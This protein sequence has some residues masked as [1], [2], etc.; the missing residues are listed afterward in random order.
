MHG[1]ETTYPGTKLDIYPDTYG[2]TYLCTKLDIYPDTYGTT[3]LGIK[4]QTQ[5]RI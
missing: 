3:Y 1:Y 4:P 5:V 2:T